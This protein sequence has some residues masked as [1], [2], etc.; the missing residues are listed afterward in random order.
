MDK[1]IENIDY[2]V[3]ED[4]GREWNFYDQRSLTEKEILDLFEQYFEIFPIDK[5]SDKLVGF[6]FGCGSGRWAKFIAPKVKK[7][8]CVDASSKALDVAKINLKY[9]KNCSFLCNHPSNLEIE[10]N[11]MDFGYSLGVLHHIPDVK[12]GLQ[13]CINK[14]KKNAPFL[15]YLYYNFDNRPKWY[16]FIWKIMNILRLF[17]SKLPFVI[18][19]PISY[20]FAL[21]F[22]YPCARLSQ[23]FEYFKFDVSNIPLSWYRNYSFKVMANDSLDRFGTKIEKRFSK[24]EILQLMESSGLEKIKFSNRQPFWCAIGYKK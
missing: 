13:V 21:L 7:L 9:N 20:I 5:L 22:Y 24:K 19:L 4:F 10:N 3:I 12:N 1:K 2:R 17:I 14:L 11:S 15:L 8:I 18:K 23:I 16:V 6:D